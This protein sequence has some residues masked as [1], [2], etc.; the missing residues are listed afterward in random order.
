MIILFMGASMVGI[1]IIGMGDGG[2][3]LSAVLFE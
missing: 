3:L 1:W 2:I